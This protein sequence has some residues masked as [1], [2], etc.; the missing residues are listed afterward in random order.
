MTTLEEQRITIE[1]YTRKYSNYKK[2]P[3]TRRTEEYLKKKEKEF[4]KLWTAISTRHQE[5][6]VDPNQPYFADKAYEKCSE[7][8]KE[9]M[10]DIE[11]RLEDIEKEKSEDSESSSISE[12][13][14]GPKTILQLEYEELYDIMSTINELDET[15][16][17]GN[18]KALMELIRRLGKNSEL[19]ISRQNQAMQ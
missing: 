5:I 8:N 1:E 10:K 13:G 7:M 17:M 6:A 12:S 2:T 19:I 11:K 14:N 4:A 18:A 3:F 15:A 16:T 9:V